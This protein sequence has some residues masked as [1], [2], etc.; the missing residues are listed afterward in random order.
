MKVSIDG[1]LGSARKINSQRQTDEE[2]GSKKKKGEVRADSV[3]IENRISS[4]LD[5]I[6][7][8]LKDVQSSLTRNQIIRDGL[9]RLD[10]DMAKG[11]RN[12]AEILGEVKFEGGKVLHDFVG[13]GLSQGVLKTKM[14]QVNNLITGDIN[15]LTRM[16]I[17]TENILASNLAGTDRFEAVL[18]NIENAFEKSGGGTINSISRLRADSVMRLI[19]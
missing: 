4:R 12:S 7:K 13:E 18:K 10:E 19:R 5:G 6:Q 2:S 15:K 8:E 1:I 17:E 11:G 16:Q 14:D 3:E 9:G